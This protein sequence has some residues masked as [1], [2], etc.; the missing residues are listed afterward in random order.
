MFTTFLV[1][2]WS[3]SLTAGSVLMVRN[4]LTGTALQNWRGWEFPRTS[5]CQRSVRG[6]SEVNT[7]PS[8][9][10]RIRFSRVS[11]IHRRATTQADPP[12]GVRIALCQKKGRPVAFR[13][14]ILRR[15]IL[16]T[17]QKWCQESRLSQTNVPQFF[18]ATGPTRP[19]T[20]CRKLVSCA[21]SERARGPTCTGPGTSSALRRCGGHGVTAP[22][23]VTVRGGPLISSTCLRRGAGATS[24]YLV[25][26]L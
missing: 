1:R 4:E 11:R 24:R 19:D 13:T 5:S 18:F 16:R 12:R 10:G 8:L 26:A 20:I 6:R 21:V 14:G 2:T 17:R 3:P 7:A 25:K 22:R 23:A 9:V 15:T